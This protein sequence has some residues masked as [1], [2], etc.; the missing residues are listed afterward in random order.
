MAGGKPTAA[1]VTIIVPWRPPAVERQ[2]TNPDRNPHPT[3]TRPPASG[4]AG[5]KIR[6][7]SKIRFRI[8]PSIRR[9]NQPSHPPGYPPFDPPT[10]PQ[11]QPASPV[12]FGSQ[13]PPERKPRWIRR[14]LVLAT[15]LILV[16]PAIAVLGPPEIAAWHLAAA[17]EERAAGNKELAYEWLADATR[18]SP[19]HPDLFLQRA[20]WRLED[21]KIEDA[22]ADANEAV[23]LSPDS[24]ETLSLRATILQHLDRHAE[25]IQDWKTIDRLSLTRGWPERAT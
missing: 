8:D 24:Y 19:G 4:R 25:A 12:P 23:E 11:Q 18:W 13:P 9:M 6:I 15:L 5:H 10:A 14:L 7:R 2:G 21:G 3:P 17:Q 22:L 16:L 1:K 20:A